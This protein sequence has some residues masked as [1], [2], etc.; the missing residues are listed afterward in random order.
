MSHHDLHNKT[1]ERLEFLA[2]WEHTWVRH[3]GYVTLA[4]PIFETSPLALARRLYRA[5]QDNY[6]VRFIDD[7][8]PLRP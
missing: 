2:E 1:R 5:K 6:P 7:T 3:N 4:A 8:K